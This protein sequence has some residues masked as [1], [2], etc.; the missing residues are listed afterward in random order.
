MTIEEA[1]GLDTKADDLPFVCLEMRL[2]LTWYPA[3]TSVWGHRKG[4][5]VDA[6]IINTLRS[7]E[8]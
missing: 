2:T 5:H 1:N 6:T 3:G 4:I 7:G 8:S